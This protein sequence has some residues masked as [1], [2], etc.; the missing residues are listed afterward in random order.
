MDLNAIGGFLR[1]LRK[2][3]GK[4]QDQL[5]EALGVT[6]K[7]VSRW[8]TGSYLPSVDMLQ[9]LSEYHG[10]TINE[11]LSARR[12]T[13]GE[14]PAAAEDNLKKTVGA[15]SF[16]LAERVAFYKKKWLREH[17]G[18]LVLLAL[19]LGALAAWGVIGR[20]PVVLGCC[21]LALAVAHGI[22]HHA[23]MVYVEAHAF[24]GS[25]Q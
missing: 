11:I 21:P 25:G 4:T 24:D 20:N 3:K 15:S 8:E 18:F 1:Q 9:A 5:G 2:E 10:I 12:L 17:I 19:G 23:M 7:T 13:P 6:G 14:Y 16:S 22:R